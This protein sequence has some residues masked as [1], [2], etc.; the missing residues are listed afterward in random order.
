[1]NSLRCS[2]TLAYLPQTTRSRPFHTS[3]VSTTK[4][5]C[6]FRKEWLSENTFDKCWRA[7]SRSPQ[8]ATNTQAQSTL[9]FQP[10]WYPPVLLHAIQEFIT[11]FSSPLLMSVGNSSRAANSLNSQY[12][13]P[14]PICHTTNYCV[15]QN[16][17]LSR[18][19]ETQRNAR[20]FLMQIWTKHH[21][22]LVYRVSWSRRSQLLLP[23]LPPNHLPAISLYL[24]SHLNLKSR[25][26]DMRK[27][28][29]PL[30]YSRVII[31]LI[32]LIPSYWVE[33]WMRIGKSFADS[34]AH[35]AYIVLLNGLRTLICSS[36]PCRRGW[37]VLRQLRSVQL[38]TFVLI[39]CCIY[40]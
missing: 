36:S 39:I 31:L 17:R 29:I 4:A 15:F 34:F 5:K 7:T 2:W 37:N 25:K 27:P 11:I 38:I 26:N 9:T 35:L 24:L 40:I 14:L 19:T 30:V 23:V 13:L 16:W 1:M 8:K 28:Y 12:P 22:P 18:I 6:W 21:S 3:F 32:C 20:C 33:Y 10:V